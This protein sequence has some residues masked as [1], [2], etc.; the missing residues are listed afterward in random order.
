M[1][2]PLPNLDDRRWAD[3]A[4][5]G[6]SLIPLYAPEWTDHNA[7][8]PGVTLMELFAWL[9]EM[10]L[11]HLNRITDRQ[12]R[13]ML[14]LM[15]IRPEPPKPSRGF[16]ELHIPAGAAMIPLPPEVEFAG[17]NLA[18]DTITFRS[19]DAV[20]VIDAQLR[21]VQW[22]DP[23]GFHNVT[24]VMLRGETFPLFG[25]DP[26]YGNELYLGLDKS[27]PTNAW[28][29]LAFCMSGEKAREDERQR[30]L[31]EK[32]T[33]T[34]PP[35]HSV[36][37]QWEFFT[38]SQWI[39]LDTHDDTRSFA[40]TGGVELRTAQTMTAQ[41]LG[42]VTEPLNYI[43]ARFASGGYDA[44][45]IAEK[46]LLNGVLAVQ[47]V[48]PWV[49]LTI[50]A[51][52]V[53]AGSAAPGQ[54]IGIQFKMDGP[55]ISELTI[56]PAPAV[57]PKF[58]LL[59]YTAPGSLVNGIL[60]IAAMAAGQG[61]SEPNQVVRLP[62]CP[63][64]ESTVQVFTREDNAWRSW[65]RRDDF[66]AS[67]RSDA[68]YLLDPTAGEMTF[69]DGEHGR[70]VPAGALLFVKCDLTAAENGQLESGQITR[71]AD[72]L[73]NRAILSDPAVLTA[74][75]VR[76]PLPTEGGAPAETLAHAIGRGIELREASWRAVT[77]RDFEVIALTTPGT[78]IARVSARPNLFPSLECI[79][80]PGVVTVLVV[81]AMPGPRPQ[82][83]A[84]LLA[85][86]AARLERRRII[87]TRVI[88]AGPSYLS[89]SV[90]A[91]VKAFPNGS[92]VRLHDDIVAALNAFFNP[93]TGG[94]EGTGWPFG[95]DVYRSEILQVLDEIPGVDHVV[96]L[97]LFA[98][99]C[100]PLCGN[101]C[102]P[103]TWLIA[104][105]PHEIEV[106]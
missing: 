45:P 77:A 104:P 88:V 63:M 89:V 87:G 65:E 91:E 72:S 20:N 47:A 76:N 9:T 101:L 18:G 103:S 40:L 6:R 68:H 100:G 25:P 52:A 93:L 62:G 97:D 49:S 99:G 92:Q 55:L 79:S 69:G 21:A 46:I 61:S 48:E 31:A 73:H 30:I 3:L 32:N 11:F 38:G 66:A 82:A 29:R 23:S 58:T 14:A 75:G 26:M 81:P 54:S 85:E 95:R 35:H 44:P 17:L 28:V 71:I 1:P 50:K 8:D 4:E 59:G 41:I 70:T 34:L 102:V 36:R 53:V 24:P 2:I 10:D 64:V 56:D 12:K 33:S 19:V 5:Q 74:M 86:V 43:R 84:G 13:R 7:S 37:V 15:G 67:R 90:R 27:L 60:T 39:A 51:G 98:D 94:P 106:V 78:N 22:R 57:D 80:A 105:G 16:V 83:S 96:S 42:S